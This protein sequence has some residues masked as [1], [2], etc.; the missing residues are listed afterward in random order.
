MKGK[1]YLILLSCLLV[2]CAHIPSISAYREPSP[3]FA[4]DTNAQISEIQDQIIQAKKLHL[5]RIYLVGGIYTDT[6]WPQER[7][8]WELQDIVWYLGDNGYTCR[9]YYKDVYGDMK[10]CRTDIGLI[11]TWN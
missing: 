6:Y 11:V 10:D 8:N 2:G 9:P 5:N 7:W 3:F 1:F 4:K